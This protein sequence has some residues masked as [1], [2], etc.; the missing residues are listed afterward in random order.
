[1]RRRILIAILS[2]TAVT[3]VLFG[4]PLAIVVQRFVDDDASLR[5]ERQ[6]VLASREVSSDF[7][8]TNDPVELPVTSDGVVIALYDE[9]GTLVA[10]TR[11]AIADAPTSRALKNEVVDVEAPGARIVA[12]PVAADERVIGVIR[13]EQSTA[14]SDR[15]SQRIFALLAALAAGVLAV[16]GT[17]GYL[18]AGRLALPVRRLRDAAVVLGDGDFTIDIPRSSIPELDEA[19]RAMTATARRLDDLVTRERAFSSDASHQLRTP[20]AGLRAAIETEIA[21]PR[22]NPTTV[23]HEAIVDIERLERTIT[24]MLTIARASDVGSSPVL[25]AEVYAEIEGTWHDRFAD[26]GRSLTTGAARYVPPVRGNASMLRHALDVLVDN[27]F[28]HGAGETRIDHIVTDE[29]VTISVTDDGPGFELNSS[30]RQRSQAGGIGPVHGLGLPLA[31]RL[32]D[33]MSGRLVIS[34]SGPH[35]QI[36]IVLQRSDPADR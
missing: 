2:I 23:L 15:R 26:A 29:S 22:D 35:P 5:V 9:H 28:R 31:R 36:D 1:M 19:A 4:V 24:E 14:A 18:V 21:F 8:T 13:A 17:I 3:I 12:V 30:P 7:A 10:G 34:R 33:A 25:L 20:L 6:A 11:P 27:A 16:G 32:I